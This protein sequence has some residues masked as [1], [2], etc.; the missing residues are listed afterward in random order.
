VDIPIHRRDGEHAAEQE[1]QRLRESFGGQLERWPDFVH[2]QQR[3]AADVT[4]LV[5]L[6]E[7]DDS[8]LLLVELPGVQR[9]DIALHVDGN[10]L[11]LTADRRE[12]ERRGLLRHRTRTTGRF[13]LAVSLPA[14]AGDGTVSASLESGLLTIEVAKAQEERRRRIPVIRR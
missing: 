3:S 7:S 9:E 12:R 2:D 10:W 14:R 11:R 8:Y 13:A 5:E 1:F 4:P 6:E